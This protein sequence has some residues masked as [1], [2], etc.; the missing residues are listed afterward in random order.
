MKPT[1]FDFEFDGKIYQVD[2]TYFSK[3]KH[4]KLTV[5]SKQIYKRKG[6]SIFLDRVI[7][8]EFL[9]TLTNLK[10]EDLNK[11]HPFEVARLFIQVDKKITRAWKLQS[12]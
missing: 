9:V 10:L 4:K 6:E 8:S 1:I 3:E 5:L 11:L 7:A 12:H 2:S